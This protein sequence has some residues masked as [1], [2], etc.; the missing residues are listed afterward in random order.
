[1]KYVLQ[2]TRIIPIVLVYTF[3]SITVVNAQTFTNPILPSGADPFCVFVDG[4]YYYTQTR[5][6]R[7]DLWK[8]KDLSRLATAEYKTIWTPPMHKMY[9]KN[10]WAPEVHYLQGKWY[11]Y[12]AADDGNNKNHRM[13]VIE[14]KNSDPFSQH[15]EIGRASCR[16]R[17]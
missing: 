14:N 4:Y 6:N 5:G 2:T 17:V 13:Y 12:F 11:V 15:W 3:N 16:E 9:S 10:I 8:T 1:M 7:I